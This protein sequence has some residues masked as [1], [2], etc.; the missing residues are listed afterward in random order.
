[1][2]AHS[3]L[4]M[5]L[6]RST[7]GVLDGC[8]PR[9]VR[10][11]ARNSRGARQHPERARARPRRTQT[12]DGGKAGA[13]LSHPPPPPMTIDRRGFLAASSS[14]LVLGK[15]GLSLPRLEPPSG[16]PEPPRF[17]AGPAREGSV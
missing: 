14:A 5:P 15:R 17:D 7:P 8:P 2:D 4:L 1:M 3:M 10:P 6:M 16:T 9:F 11:R 13:Q 12:A